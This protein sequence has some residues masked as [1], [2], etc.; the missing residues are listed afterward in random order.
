MNAPLLEWCARLLAIVW[1]GFWL[2][3]FV[4]ESVATHSSL[5]V[6]APWIGLGFLFFLVAWIPWRWEI[7]GAL[8]LIAFSLTGGLA[9]AVQ[10]PAGMPIATLV[11]AIL[12]YSVPSLS[13]GVLF[14][15]HHRALAA[16]GRHRDV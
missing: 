5:R 12:A 11:V 10:R 13:A 1:G 3:F 2:Y 16:H 7:F 8:V 14:V 4:V 6:A 15:L 9:Y